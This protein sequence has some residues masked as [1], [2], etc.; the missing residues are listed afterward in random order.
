MDDSSYAELMLDFGADY[1]DCDPFPTDYGMYGY[2]SFGRVFDANS[3]RALRMIGLDEEGFDLVGEVYAGLNNAL[4]AAFP[5]QSCSDASAAN[6]RENAMSVLRNPSTK[7]VVAVDMK[8]G[9][10]M[11]GLKNYL[12]RGGSII[13]C[14]NSPGMTCAPDMN[15]VYESLGLPWRM[16]DY[17]RSDFT[18]NQS[19]VVGEAWRLFPAEFNVKAVRIANATCEQSLF[20][21]PDTASSSAVL[22]R[23]G[24]AGG[25][26]AFF[27][28]VNGEPETDMS[29]VALIKWL[30]A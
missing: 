25:Y 2:S 18:V 22:A 27:G 14:C 10:V 3:T 6:N 29:I 12:A 28:D 11:P 8:V 26:I 1:G 4:V 7:V 30:L 16:G 19:S 13:F 24:T 9:S 5:E 15:R 23:Y 17:H 21:E 20:L